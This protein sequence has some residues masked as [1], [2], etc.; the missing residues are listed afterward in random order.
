[1]ASYPLDEPRPTAIA[2]F[3]SK[4]IAHSRADIIGAVLGRHASLCCTLPPRATSS[5]CR[6]PHDGGAVRDRLEALG[7]ARGETAMSSM[8][9][10]VYTSAHLI[11]AVSYPLPQQVCEQYRDDK[12]PFYGEYTFR[13]EAHAVRPQVQVSIPER[14]RFESDCQTLHGGMKN[15]RQ[16]PNGDVEMHSPR[17]MDGSIK[18]T[19]IK[20]KDRLKNK[21]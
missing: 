19:I 5:A 17:N 20:F 18:F 14:E 13:C 2:R 3:V 21:P 16:L 9:L 10:V 8:F 15:C 4:G 7:G 1:M 6:I 11:G 12:A